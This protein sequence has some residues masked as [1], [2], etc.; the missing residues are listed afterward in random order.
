MKFVILQNI[1]QK[2]MD[3]DNLDGETGDINV[4]CG[5]EKHDIPSQGPGASN[6][7]YV[8]PVRKKSAR[9]NLKGIECMQCKNFYDAVLPNESKKANGNEQNPRCEHHDG[10]SRHCYW[11]A[12][13]STP[14]GF[15]NIK[16]ELEM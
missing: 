10:V 1:P 15:F 9:G 16:F 12:P 8:E 7:K 6:F 14:V 5:P 3:F 13:P 2:T 4:I 11:Y